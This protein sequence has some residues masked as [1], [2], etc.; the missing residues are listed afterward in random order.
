MSPE[1]VVLYLKTR[2]STDIQ[3]AHYATCWLFIY[4]S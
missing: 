1:S 4:A 3:G 2:G